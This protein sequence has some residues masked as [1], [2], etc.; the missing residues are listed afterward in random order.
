MSGPFVG[1]AA[2]DP[3]RQPADGQRRDQRAEPVEPAGRLRVARLLRRGARVAHR[4]KAS[5]GTLIRKATRQPSV[6]TRLPPT[7]GPKI[8]SAA[9]D[10]AQMPNARPR[11]APSK[12]WVMR[13]SEPGMSSAPAAPW[14]RR[15]TISHSSV[16][17]SPHSAE[18]AAK[19]DQADGVDPPP[20]VVVGQRAGQDQQRGEDR[21]VAADDV[22]LALEDADEGPRQVLADVLERDVDDGRSRGRPHP[23]R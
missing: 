12:A 16:G 21:Q 4:A 1:L 17:A 14:A 19:P 22:G 5:S 8:V 20:T 13:A 10:A 23:N 15:K 2:D 9:V 11:S 18:V 3:E 6:S 7:I